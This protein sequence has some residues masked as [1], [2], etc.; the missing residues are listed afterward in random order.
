MYTQGCTGR[1]CTGRCTTTRVYLR[2]Y[3]YLGIPQGVHHTAHGPQGVHHTA[4]GPQGVAYPPV[5]LAGC[6]I[7][8]SVPLRGVYYPPMVLRVCTTR[9]CPQGVYAVMLSLGVYARHAV[10]RCVPGCVSLGVYPAVY[11]SVCPPLYPLL[12][13]FDHRCAHL[14]APF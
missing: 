12:F 6:G 9:P 14:S 5:Y 3:Y 8:T 2:V 10:P 1:L 4:H 7:P 11:P 13:P